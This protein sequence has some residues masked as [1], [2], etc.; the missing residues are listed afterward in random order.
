MRGSTELLLTRCRAFVDW[1]Y[2]KAVRGLLGEGRR[3]TRDEA[4]WIAKPPML[5]RARDR[6]AAAENRLPI[7]L[8]QFIP[9]RP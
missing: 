1:F 4:Q 2:D 6:K 9:F 3:L 8:F 7:V 5:L